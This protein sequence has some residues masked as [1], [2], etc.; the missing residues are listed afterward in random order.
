MKYRK[1]PLRKI[2]GRLRGGKRP[3]NPFAK[4]SIANKAMGLRMGISDVMQKGRRLL[5]TGKKAGRQGLKAAKK[6][7]AKGLSAAKKASMKAKMQAKKTAAA[8][9]KKLK[10]A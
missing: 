4:G 6:M 8:S 9:M 10:Q 2:R 3:K 1:L 5:K 7:G